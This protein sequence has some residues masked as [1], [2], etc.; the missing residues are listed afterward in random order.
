MNSTGKKHTSGWHGVKT[1][2]SHGTGGFR[3][4]AEIRRDE[5]TRKLQKREEYLRMLEEMEQEE[6]KKKQRPK[7]VTYEI[8]EPNETDW[9]QVLGLPLRNRI[10]D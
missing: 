6:L 2:A 8:T 10:T 9:Y 7:I 1:M 5:K 4:I 3:T